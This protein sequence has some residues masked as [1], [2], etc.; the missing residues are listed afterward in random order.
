MS[1]YQIG[2]TGGIGSGKST[3]AGLFAEQGIT[4]VDADQIARDVVAP[5][6]KALTMIAERFGHE[7]LD[8]DGQ[9]QR[10]ALRQHVFD[11][12]QQRHWLNNL[13]HPLIRHSMEEQAAQAASPYVMVMVPLL[14]ES[15][16]HHRLAR[17]LV[18]DV[19]E[20]VQLKR[21]LQRD[22]SDRITARRIIDAQIGRQQRLALADDVID[23]N[24]SLSEVAADVIHLHVK[25]LSLAAARGSSH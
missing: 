22:S 25:Y 15:G 18:V 14:F 8:H 4:I 5:G 17:T 21:V 12:E 11:D 3:V 7:V 9:L 19:P 6:S 24:R 20:S 1:D 16:W 10:A 2:L 23:N 13:L